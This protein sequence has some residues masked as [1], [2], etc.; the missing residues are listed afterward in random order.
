MTGHDHDRH[1]CR[2]LPPPPPDAELA[3]ME[4]TMG[5]APEGT[6]PH[7]WARG[8]LDVTR[9]PQPRQVRLRDGTRR[10]VEWEVKWFLDRVSGTDRSTASKRLYDVFLHPDGWTRAG[11]RWRRTTDRAAAHIVIRVI[12]QDETVCGPGSAGCYS[13]GYEADGKAVAEMGVEHI[14]REGPWRVISGMEC[15]GHGTFRIHD[16]Y[17]NHPNYQGVMGDWKSTTLF[18]Y[19]PSN[20]EIEGAKVWLAGQAPAALVHGH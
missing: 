15:C 6:P 2:G 3:R 13:W 11:V 18:G 12:P 20:E 1:T 17:I 14:D 4:R 10:T 16:G 9:L 5:A 7:F 19:S 8:P